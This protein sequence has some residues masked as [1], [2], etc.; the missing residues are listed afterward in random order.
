[1]TTGTVNELGSCYRQRSD[2]RLPGHLKSRHSEVRGLTLQITFSKD[3]GFYALSLE[4]T[5]EVAPGEVAPVATN[6][7]HD[8]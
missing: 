8:R 7:P 4:V 2:L 6:I 5:R 1:M 3:L